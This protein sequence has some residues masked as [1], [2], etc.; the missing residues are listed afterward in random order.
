MAI[1][2]DPLSRN[3]DL[4]RNL[5]TSFLSGSEVFSSWQFDSIQALITRHSQQLR[6]IWSDARAAQE[7]AQWSEALQSGMRNAIKMNRDCLIA[8]TDYQMETLRLLQDMS[9][10]MQ[11]V[12]TDA[13]NEQLVNIDL[14]GSRAKRNGKAT[15][16]ASQKL[17]A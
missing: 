13:M 8:S 11:Q 4:F 2:S 14:L 1:Q 10:E 5:S 17:A 9:S 15:A 16:L 6:A 12:M 3:V 7:P